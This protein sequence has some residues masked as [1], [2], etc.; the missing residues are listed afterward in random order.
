MFVVILDHECRGG[1]EGYNIDLELV[2]G[3]VPFEF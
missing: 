3:L 2:G 1:K